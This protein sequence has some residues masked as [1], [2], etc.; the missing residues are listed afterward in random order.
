[1]RKVFL[2]ICEGETE[3]AYVDA[4]KKYF[5]LPITIKTK[6]CGSAINHRLIKQ[7]VE[8]LGIEREDEYRIFYIYDS[9]VQCVVDKIKALPGDLIL[10]NPCIELWF[11]LHSVEYTRSQDSKSIIKDL[12]KCHTAWASYAKGALS[13]DQIGILLNRRSHAIE[14]SKRLDWPF[15]PSSNM[16]VFLEALESEKTLK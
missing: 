8:E 4:L 9:D 2:I 16:Y 13:R 6:V 1:M 10:T 5:R 12:S 15:N 11:M 14:R 3:G 7:Y